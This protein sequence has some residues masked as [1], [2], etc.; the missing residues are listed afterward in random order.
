MYRYILFINLELVKIIKLMLILGQVRL[1]KGQLCLSGLG[2]GLGYGPTGLQFPAGARN[3][4]RFNSPR[5]SILPLRA[6]DPNVINE[7]MHILKRL[8]MNCTNKNDKIHKSAAHHMNKDSYL[9]INMFKMDVWTYC[10]ALRLYHHFARIKIDWM[11]LAWLD[12]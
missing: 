10:F 3:S 5:S 6:P 8:S 12:Y 9:Q 11:I 2:K 1:N 7:V 4:K